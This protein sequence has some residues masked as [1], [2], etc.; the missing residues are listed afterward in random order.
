MDFG[1]G[2]TAKSLRGAVG[3]GLGTTNKV[4]RGSTSDAAGKGL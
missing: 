2:T 1:L 3:I 4:L